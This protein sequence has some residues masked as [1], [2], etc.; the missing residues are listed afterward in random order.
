MK[1]VIFFI[2]IL[3]STVSF[4]TQ[5]PVQ[6]TDNVKRVFYN[7][8]VLAIEKWYGNNQKLD[9][10]KTYHKSG[11]LNELFYYNNGR[12]QG[13]SYKFNRFG[14]KLTTW[15]FNN[16]ILVN[17]I[18]HKIEYNKT[19]EEKVKQQHAR[20]RELNQQ[21]K[22][23]PKNF[24]AVYSRAHIRY[25]RG[26]HTLALHDFNNIEKYLLKI[27][28]PKITPTKPLS[29]IYDCIGAIYSSYEMENQAIHYRYKAVKTA[30]DDMRLHFNLGAYLYTVKSYRLAINYLDKVL[31]K[32][33]NHAFTHRVLAALYTD[34]EDYEKALQHINIAFQNEAQL[35]K[36]GD[37]NLERDLR[38][39][40]GFLYHKL[41][42]SEKGIA[43]L[44]EALNINKDNS[45]AFRNLGVIYHDLGN[46]E[47]ACEYLQKAKDLGY[48]KIH[49][50]YDLQTYL[51]HSCQSNI[52][53]ELEIEAKT[54]IALEPV[55]IIKL[56]DKPFVH[57]NPAVGIVNVEKID[58][59]NFNFE[60]YDFESKLIKQG[61]SNNKSVDFSG[62]PSGLYIL[63]IEKTG[64]RHFFKIVKE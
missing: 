59:E 22:V 26:N 35:I 13:K 63:N 34:F 12:Y 27:N 31:T 11:E 62:L 46:Y 64:R 38:T 24:G 61:I 29:S 20:L 58:F 39:I 52:V 42:D 19:D 7:D 4:A 9:S 40:R 25:M 60:I 54:E 44:E 55:Q 57:P 10:L 1:H 6:K 41:G 33:K 43:D 48:E 15:E 50:R 21:L 45:F 28:N 32:W 56:I 17:R 16:G 53:S 36:L 51:E 5:S 47:K 23:N 30:P 49:D 14:E 8:G 18:D 2:V 3:I 37:G